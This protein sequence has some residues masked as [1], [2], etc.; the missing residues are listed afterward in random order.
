MLGRSLLSLSLLYVVTNLLE[1]ESIAHMF[2]GSRLE[3]VQGGW[4]TCMLET[5]S[6][7]RE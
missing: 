2:V 3:W 5:G 7:R 4:N 6:F 1:Y